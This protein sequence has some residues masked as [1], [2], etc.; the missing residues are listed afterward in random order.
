MYTIHEL[1]IYCNDEI[2]YNVVC[3]MVRPCSTSTY[4]IVLCGRGDQPVSISFG[5]YGIM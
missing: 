2:L 3:L 4:P 1:F 5:E